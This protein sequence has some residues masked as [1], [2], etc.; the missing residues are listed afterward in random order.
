M[1]G[2]GGGSVGPEVVVV[3]L[4]EFIF[5]VV[6]VECFAFEVLVPI[7]EFPPADEA[8]PVES[9]L[10]TVLVPVVVVFLSEVCEVVTLF[11]SEVTVFAFLSVTSE[12][13]AFVETLLLLLVTGAIISDSELLISLT[14]CLRFFIKYE[15]VP[16]RPTERMRAAAIAANLC[17]PDL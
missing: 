8:L 15:P 7:R 10:F 17:H 13:S 14:L 5:V 9:V 6:L 1:I 4:P 16:A 2:G 3:V 12:D 11:L